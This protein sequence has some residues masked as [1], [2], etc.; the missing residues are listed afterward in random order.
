MVQI[1][2]S[3]PS[4]ATLRQQA[5]DQ[6]LQGVIQGVGAYQTQE[7]NKRQMA[8]AEEA[9]KRQQGQQDLQNILALSQQGIQDPRAALDQA[10]NGRQVITPAMEAQP[11][12]YGGEMQGP[13]QPGQGP[14]R[15]LLSEARP[16]TQEVLS[17]DYLNTYTARKQA[18][19]DFKK[20]ELE[21]A[22]KLQELQ[23][24]KLE[25]ELGN[26]PLEEKKK[27]KEYEKL[28]LQTEKERLELGVKRAEAGPEVIPGF[29]KTTTAKT[30]EKD[31]EELKKTSGFYRDVE[32][33]GNKLIDNIN[34][35]GV[36]TRY[37]LSEGSRL[38]AQNITAL[39]LKLKDMA[40]LGALTGP[41][42]DLLNK[43]IGSIQ[44]N[45]A[46]G[47]VSPEQAI[48]QVKAVVDQSKESLKSNAKS[49]GFEIVDQGAD[50][51][52]QRLLELRQKAQG[53]Q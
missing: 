14:L 47:L 39:Q 52:Q 42:M 30:S 46:V 28:G 23:S 35:F 38:T 24:Q 6:A 51:K 40:G 3:G 21:R 53:G 2:Q 13:V 44:G 7:Q 4:T 29:I 18:E 43:S 49:R 9:I 10:K 17:P 11:A 20:S 22:R 37:G 33:L 45:L 8:M 50:V 34:K 48:R 1:I 12:Q 32:N 16:A 15:A 36:T 19:I 25:R 5:M 41:D 26:A 31:K 27:Q